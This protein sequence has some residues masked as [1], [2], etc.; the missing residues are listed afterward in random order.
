MFR[1]RLYFTYLSYTRIMATKA[2]P[3]LTQPKQ[4][5]KD[6]T[7]SKMSLNPVPDNGKP[8][9]VNLL[10]LQVFVLTRIGKLN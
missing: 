1:Y 8:S 6:D 2:M 5:K 7:P 4:S 9:F 3:L 10:F